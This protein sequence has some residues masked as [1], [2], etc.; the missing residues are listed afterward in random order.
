[1]KRIHIL[2]AIAAMAVSATATAAPA[3]TPLAIAVEAGDLDLGSDKGQRILALRL[4]R[5]AS[6]LCK[7][8]AVASLPRNL[9]SERACIREARAGAQAIAKTRTAAGAA[10]SDARSSDT[11]QNS[12]Y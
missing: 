1:M 8:E 6:A 5:A 4:Q 11:G 3:P 10:D 12:R 7:T 9:R 2:L